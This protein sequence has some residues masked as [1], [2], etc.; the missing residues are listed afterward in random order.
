MLLSQTNISCDELEDGV[1]KLNDILIS[2]AKKASFAKRIKISKKTDRKKQNQWFTKECKA[3]QKLVRKY[4]KELSAS[5]FDKTKRQNFVKARSAYKKVCRKAEATSRK[6]LTEKLIKIGQNDPKLF[7]TTIKKMNNWGK[8]ATDPT[9]KISPEKWINHFE[10]LLNDKNGNTPQIDERPKTFMPILDS[11]ISLKEL[12]DALKNLKGGKSPGPDKILGE[13]LIIFGKTY[14]HILLRLTNVIFS[15]HI[16]PSQWTLN[17]LKPIFKKGESNDPNNFR[18]LA[19]GSSFAKLFSFILLKRLTNFIDCNKILSPK[20]IGFIKGNGTSDHIFLLQTIIEKV[21]KR[22]KKKL[23]AIFI[24]FKKAYDTVNRDILMKRLRSLGIDGLFL[25]NIFSMYKKTEYCV[26]LKN[27][28][29][30]AINSNL[31][32]KQGCPLS[33][34]LFNLYIDDIND[35]FDDKCDPICIQNEQINHFLYADDLVILSQTKEGLQRGIDKAY[36]YAQSKHMTISETKSKSMVFNQSGRFLRDSFTLNNKKLESVQSFCYLGFDIKCSGT[37]KHGMNILSDKGNKALRP[38]LCAIAR[39]NI[40]AKTAI[41]LFHTYIAPILLYN[42]ENWSIISDRG[43]GKFDKDYIFNETAT[44]KTDIIHRKILKY[45][46]GVTRSCPNFAL[47]GDSGDIPLSIKGYRL[48]LNFWHRVTNLPN[49]YLVKKALLENIELQTNWIKTI[50]K[51]INTFNLADKIGNH[52]KFKNTTK[53]VMEDAYKQFWNESIS[54]RSNRRLIFYERI[55]NEF[56][57]ETYL[58]I[59]RFELRRIIAKMRCSDH[60]LRIEKGRHNNTPPLER[61]CTICH[62][63]QIEDEEHFLFKCTKYNILRSKYHFGQS[64]TAEDLFNDAD[65][66]TLGKYLVEAFSMREGE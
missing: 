28:H 9:D 11:R 56:K 54:A 4:S 6:Y 59:E 37:V 22:G 7:W 57:T 20:Q 15:E 25:S 21:V 64:M 27:G 65:Q 13:Y 48:T 10:T 8:M 12:H 14:E 43:L 17:F 45:V 60:G 40:P 33:P 30:R 35:I 63:G 26:K 44:S 53:R 19:I 58:D 24:D 1:F 34:M 62:D 3:K 38:L 51:L 29:T 5:P 42:T 50:E 2:A 52:K 55:K 46:L 39:F 61:I 16:Y 49:T 23:Y 47:Y 66:R 32:L 18:G 41:N 36:Q 31:G